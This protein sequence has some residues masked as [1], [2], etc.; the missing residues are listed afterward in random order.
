MGTSW[1]RQDM[2]NKWVNIW[3]GFTSP[4]GRST[5]WHVLGRIP[6]WVEVGMFFSIIRGETLRTSHKLLTDKSYLVTSY[7]AKLTRLPFY[8][9]LGPCC[10]FIEWNVLISFWFED[11]KGDIWTKDQD[12]SYNQHL[13]HSPHHYPGE[14]KS[15]KTPGSCH[16]PF[17]K[18]KNE[19]QKQAPSLLN[20]DWYPR[21]PGVCQNASCSFWPNWRMHNHCMKKEVI[22]FRKPLEVGLKLAITLKYL[23]TG[24]TYMSLQC[25]WLAS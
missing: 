15:H 25:H 8:K 10:V 18:T 1:L 24:E 3:V 14:V 9:T 17:N 13:H 7:S 19:C 4:G 12:L 20:T 21:L 11:K 6:T 16:V 5:F 23:A 2:L 22:N